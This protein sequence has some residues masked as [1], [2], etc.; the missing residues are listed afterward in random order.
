MTAEHVI[1]IIDHLEA[2]RLYVGWLLAVAFLGII[3][4]S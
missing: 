4:R 1:Q 3:L 2:I